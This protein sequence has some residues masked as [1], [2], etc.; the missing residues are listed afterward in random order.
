MYRPEAS[1]SMGGF[2]SHLDQVFSGALAGLHLQGLGHNLTAREA[3]MP[4]LVSPLPSQCTS[5]DMGNGQ[6]NKVTETVFTGSREFIMLA[7]SKP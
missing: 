7:D 1:V 4:T 3:K 6:G 2:P 5:N